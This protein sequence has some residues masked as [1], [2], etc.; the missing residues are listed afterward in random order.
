MSFEVGVIGGGIAG[1]S[2]ALQLA[3]KGALVSLF[4]STDRLLGESS[5][6]TSHCF[7]AGFYHSDSHAAQI[8]L[9]ASI[10][11][12]RYLQ[13]KTGEAFFVTQTP[14]N[15]ELLNQI[16][17]VIKKD[18]VLDVKT[19]LD[20]FEVLKK[21]YAELVRKDPGNAVYGPVDNFYRVAENWEPYAGLIQLDSI[22]A[23]IETADAMFDW[24]KLKSYLLA[25]LITNPNITIYYQTTVCQIQSGNKE[26]GTPAKIVTTAGAAYAFDYLVNAAWRN[27]DRLNRTLDLSSETS[28]DNK[29]SVIA[30]LEVPQPLRHRSFFLGYDNYIFLTAGAQQKS[31]LTFSPVSYQHIVSALAPE[32]HEEALMSDLIEHGQGLAAEILK[33]AA[34]YFPPLEQAIVTE[35]KIGVIR[36]GQAPDLSIDKPAED[37]AL[38]QYMGVSVPRDRYVVNEA[39]QH[40]FWYANARR[41]ADIIE[42]DHCDTRVELL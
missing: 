27:S 12:I 28:L 14:D 19:A 24:P 37:T 9:E 20:Q 15:P 42:Q 30:T 8:S 25:E 10:Q 6:A 18:S 29:I 2:T 34:A 1:V 21:C 4:E 26:L 23:I 41:V 31:Y 40:T 5:D 13:E 22:D 39:R 36:A 3:A 35:V 11:L 7:G 33:G 32:G 17:Y 38:S 16:A